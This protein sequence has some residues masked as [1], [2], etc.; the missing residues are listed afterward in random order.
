MKKYKQLLENIHSLQEYKRGFK[1]QAAARDVVRSRTFIASKRGQRSTDAVDHT[2]QYRW[3]A[4]RPDKPGSGEPDTQLLAFNREVERG[5]GK[6]QQ[7]TA[8]NR[9]AAV[10]KVEGAAKAERIRSQTERMQTTEKAA[11]TLGIP[12]INAIL[13]GEHDE[14]D[15]AGVT[16]VGH[17]KNGYIAMHQG[18]KHFRHPNGKTH[19][20]VELQPSAN[21]IGV[22]ASRAGNKK[23]TKAIAYLH[24]KGDALPV[25]GSVK[26]GKVTVDAEDDL[27]KR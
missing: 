15:V 14:G 6:T 2:G 18:V 27:N 24:P 3:A 22:W 17:E 4:E 26:S 19:A 9:A 11:K 25:S 21:G 8:R 7:Q 1:S 23:S 16:V 20:N 5:I 12:D 13:E 10:G